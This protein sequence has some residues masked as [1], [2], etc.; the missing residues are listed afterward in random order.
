MSIVKSES[1]ELPSSTLDRT[2]EIGSSVYKL[3]NKTQVY[4]RP[5]HISGF[6]HL[7]SVVVIGEPHNDANGQFDLFKG[8]E[9]FF[10]DNPSLISKTIFLSEGHPA[11]EP[12][13]VQSLIKEDP[14]PSEKMIKQ[15]LGSYLITG[16]MAFEWKYQ[17]HIQI[18]GTED[19]GLYE[20]GRQLA[21][22][23]LENPDA[24]FQKRTYENGTVVEIPL[25]DAFGFSISARNKRIAE[26]VIEKMKE[27]ENP[28]L[29]VG[30]GHLQQNRNK[31]IVQNFELVKSRMIDAQHHGPFG[32][33]EFE[34]GIMGSGAA[35]YRAVK[36]DCENFGIS[37]YFKRE[38]IGYTFLDPLKDSGVNDQDAYSRLY[39]IQR[40]LFNPDK[41]DAYQ[42]YINTY[43][44]KKT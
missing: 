40:D 21:S 25:R 44:S 34:P 27:Y 8:L 20:L 15:V 23:Y 42:N 28:I 35:L 17:H 14:A 32:M 29:F 22:V 3:S 43:L 26:T 18:V 5:T 13:S 10:Q 11:N 4:L 24:I 39:K 38:S 33:M 1:G 7:K 9:S 2:V 31:L 36:E 19:A 6:Q 12:I 41:S 37:E 16:Y 30:E